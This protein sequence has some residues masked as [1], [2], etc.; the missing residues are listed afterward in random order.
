MELDI[1][2][3]TEQ[4]GDMLYGKMVKQLVSNDAGIMKILNA[5]RYAGVRWETIMKA[6]TI[7]AERE[8]ENDSSDDMGAGRT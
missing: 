8:K 4:I 2:G 6:L 7:Y 1:Q 3:I 5:F